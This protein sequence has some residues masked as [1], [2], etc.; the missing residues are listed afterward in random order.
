MSAPVQQWD[1]VLVD[2]VHGKTIHLVPVDDLVA[3]EIAS[4][5]ICG[6]HVEPL[7]STD[8]LVAHHALDRRP[9]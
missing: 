7:G 4:D 3:H 9:E 8:Q 6:P 2:R 5:C 1:D